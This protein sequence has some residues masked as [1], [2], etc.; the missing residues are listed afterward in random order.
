MSNSITTSGLSALTRALSDYTYSKVEIDD[1]IQ[2]VET[3]PLNVISETTPNTG[4]VN[5]NNKKITNLAEGTVASD[6]V[7][8]A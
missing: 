7:T 4:P 8:K 6:A 2:P 3:T 1:K 5:M